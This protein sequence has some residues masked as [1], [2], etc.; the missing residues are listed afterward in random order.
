VRAREIFNVA[1]LNEMGK[2]KKA[3]MAPLREKVRVWGSSE[4]K[5]RPG[6]ATGFESTALSAQRGSKTYRMH[7]EG[8]KVINYTRQ[9][10][11]GDGV[12]VISP[13][14]NFAYWER[15]AV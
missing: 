1:G 8:K 9:T 15:V 12:K 13:T 5:V 4:R 14:R 2:K 10:K 6:A 7:V 3:G 11:K